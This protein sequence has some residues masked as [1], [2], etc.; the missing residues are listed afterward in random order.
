MCGGRAEDSQGHKFQ[1]LVDLQKGLLV[2]FDEVE[3]GVDE[4]QQAGEVAVLAIEDLI[5]GHLL[6]GVVH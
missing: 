5:D 4:R 1:V 6:I 3:I 2:A